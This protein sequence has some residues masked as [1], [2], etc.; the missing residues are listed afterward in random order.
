MAAAD[1]QD[2][3]S[4]V[5]APTPP[6]VRGFFA[7]VVLFKDKVILSW[8][9]PIAAV[10]GI[11]AWVVVA[12][13]DAPAVLERLTGAGIAVSSAL[14]GVVIAALAVIVA[15]LDD[16]FTALMDRATKDRYGGMEGQLFP[17]WFVTGLGILTVL[18]SVGI[19]AF[20]TDAPGWLARV[21]VGFVALLL[22]W[23]ALGVFN[24]VSYLH[25]TGV[26]K[27]LWIRKQTERERGNDGGDKSPPPS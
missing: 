6:S 7:S 15:F 23:T 12:D 26:S 18:V 27:A 25:A 22:V 21:L 4:H 5:T 24:I 19:T 14:V 16:E 9:L 10:L 3:G 1:R 8:D 17:F 11:L 2:Q 20:A 13:A